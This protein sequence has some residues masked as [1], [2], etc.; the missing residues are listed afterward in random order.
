A[1][2]P[3]ERNLIGSL[4]SLLGSHFERTRRAEER[5]ELTRAQ[6][7][8][9]EAEAA[10]RMKDAFLATVSHELRRPLTAIIGWTRML[11]EAGAADSARA[12]D[13]IE[14]NANI[15]LRLIEE[16][17]DLSRA[18]TGQLGVRLSLVNLNAILQNVADAA[19]PTASDR[20]V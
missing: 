12:L 11:R 16:L 13:V 15:Q 20:N 18:A 10:N 4:A 19:S 6:A 5:L 2:L 9:T 14:R 3:E 8:Q 17:L 1:F 7:S